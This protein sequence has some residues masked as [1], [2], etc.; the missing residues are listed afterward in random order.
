MYPAAEPKTDS[1][2]EM[3]FDWKPAQRHTIDC[4]VAAPRKG[5]HLQRNGA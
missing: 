3:S 4:A 1:Y 5:R 2:L